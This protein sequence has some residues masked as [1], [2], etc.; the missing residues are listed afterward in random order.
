MKLRHLLFYALLIVSFSIFSKEKESIY[1]LCD[2]YNDISKSKYERNA[3]IL[4]SKYSLL[5]PNARSSLKTEGLLPSD[6]KFIDSVKAQYDLKIMLN[7]A[8]IWKS[9]VGGDVG[10]EIANKYLMSWVHEY[11]PD[12]NPINETA[13]DQL[14][15]T[16]IIIKPRISNK[17]RVII[18]N[19]LSSW[20]SGYVI[21][22]KKA[23]KNGIWVNNWQSYRVKIVTYIAIAT[24][25]SD[26][27]KEAKRLFKEQVR[28]NINSDGVTLDY[29]ERDAIHYVVADLFPLMQTANLAKNYYKEDW[30]SW[31]A[32]NG[33][34]LKK[35]MLWL[36]PY[37]TGDKKK[38]EFIKSKV[39]FDKERAIAG[40]KGFT[41]QFDPKV[42]TSL[43]WLTTLVDP[44]YLN[45]AKILADNPPWNNEF[46]Y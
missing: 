22:I 46:C 35:A 45:L 13:F 11:K 29:K 23:Q 21:R 37:I 28:N 32:D 19:Y 16:Y 44:S 7:S 1:N 43:I 20:G 31:S 5:K 36:K 25:N 33:A 12:F 41:G 18:E 27:L 26:L 39:A 42:A 10:F 3:L 2:N 17:N 24:E 34:S 38:N 6:H 8:K 30:Y 15:M 9:N 14:F 4:L 40:V